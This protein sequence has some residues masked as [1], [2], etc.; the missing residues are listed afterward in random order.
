MVLL[1]GGTKSGLVDAG[2]ARLWVS[3]TGS[4]P[5]LILLHGI[6]ESSWCWRQVIPVL[7]R[8]HRVVAIDSLGHGGSQRLLSA[9]HSLAGNARRV[10]MAC[11]SMGIDRA[12]WVGTSYGGAVAMQAAVEDPTA[13]EKL[14]LMA[15]AHPFAGG[16][17][18]LA[19]WYGTPLGTLAAHVYVYVPERV[20][21][22]AMGRMF[23]DPSLCTAEMASRYFAP[24]KTRHTIASILSC[25]KTYGTDMQNLHA[26]LPRLK[27]LPVRLIW[28]DCD[29]VVPHNSAA[30]L[31]QEFDDVRLYTMEHV[32]HLPYEE[33]P[34]A[35]EKL[36]LK[37]LAE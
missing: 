29:P 1:S 5:A 3:E 27:T 12:T 7:S 15:P 22:W 2:D 11:R 25:L 26:R 28:G 30:R 13:V 32:G 8:S 10:L 24:F 16:A 33:Q 19:R 34:R 37:A 35:L 6:I 18:D 4:G 31:M 14:V 36:L 20:F 23:A 21:Q 17:I 9:D